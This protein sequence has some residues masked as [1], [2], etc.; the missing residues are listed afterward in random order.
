MVIQHRDESATGLWP[1]TSAVVSLCLL[2]HP[3][4][5]LVLLSL[6]SPAF[7]AGFFNDVVLSSWRTL[8]I[9][10]TGQAK[11]G[12]YD[13]SACVPRCYAKILVQRAIVFANMRAL[14]DE[15]NCGE[16]IA[17]EI[18]RRRDCCELYPGC[19]HVSNW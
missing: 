11:R 5:R 4:C 6:S 18:Y 8:I 1:T 2:T 7:R 3:I 17:D 9:W 19:C 10:G 16:N 14:F 13:R 12:G 15:S